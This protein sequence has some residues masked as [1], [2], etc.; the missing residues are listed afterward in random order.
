MTVNVSVLYSFTANDLM[1]KAVAHNGISG[2][3]VDST[4][5]LIFVDTVD[6]Q[7]GQ[8]TELSKTANGYASAPIVMSQFTGSDGYWP[9]SSLVTDSSGNL[10]GV[11]N[12]AVRFFKRG[13]L[14]PVTAP[15]M[16]SAGRARVM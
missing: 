11:L 16:K 7:N 13:S 10:Y 12:M 14:T 6:G 15:C 4:G 1:A 5:N 9:Q 8:I 2:V 3:I